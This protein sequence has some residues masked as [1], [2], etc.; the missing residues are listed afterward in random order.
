MNAAAPAWLRAQ[1]R[2][3][4]LQALWLS[5]LSL[6]AAGLAWNL[7]WFFFVL[8]LLGAVVAARGDLGPDVPPWLYPTAFAMVGFLLA[9]GMVDHF[10]RRYAGASDRSIIGWHLLGDF[11]LLP[12]RLTFAVWGNLSAI[13]WLSPMELERAWELLILI[14]RDGKGRLSALTLV[15]PDPDRLYRLLSTLQML[16][17]IDLH[18]GEGDWFYTVR[19]TRWEELGKLLASGDKNH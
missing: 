10:R 8:I 13:R 5:I 11:L 14:Q 4:N 17:L 15:E 2:S 1:V 6:A 12:V 16:D 3:H 19:S 9:W 18:R 7:A